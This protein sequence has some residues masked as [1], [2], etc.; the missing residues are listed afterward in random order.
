MFGMGMYYALRLGGLAEAKL[1]RGL[2]NGACAASVE[3][4]RAAD[5][6]DAAAV[7]TF[8]EAAV[9]AGEATRQAVQQA[10]LNSANSGCSI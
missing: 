8:V 6:T 3:Q 4:A 1:A 9:S 10:W 5:A 7:K 2:D